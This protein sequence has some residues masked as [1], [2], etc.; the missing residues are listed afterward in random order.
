LVAFATL[1]TA[2]IMISVAPAFTVWS[3]TE[4]LA[5][6]GT[7]MLLVAAVAILHFGRRLSNNLRT[8]ESAATLARSELQVTLDN[9][10]QGLVLCDNSANVVAVNNRFLQLFNIP[11]SKVHRGMEVADLIR[12][13]AQAG[14][15]PSEMAEAL[16]KERLTRQPGSSGRVE[17]PLR[18]RIFD[19]AY[20]PRPEGGWACTFEDVTAQKEAVQ[21]LAFLAQH[22]SLT[23]LANRSLLG[24][25]IDMAIGEGAEFAVMLV[26]LDQFKPVNDALGHATGDALLREVAARLRSLVRDGDTA[27]RLGGDEF[28]ILIRSPCSHEDADRL[29]ATLVQSLTLPFDLEG[30]EIRI[31]G[32]IGVSLGLAAEDDQRGGPPRAASLLRQADLALYRA[33][34]DGRGCH[35]F[36]EPSLDET[37]LYKCA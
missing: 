10:S 21:R 33:K 25:R 17:L 5:P 19:I 31:G 8:A 32:S 12:L 14:G 4:A 2:A 13:Q 35:R 24:E 11:S 1:C 7:A 15:M 3:G 6:A 36:F 18:Q 34:Q 16:I 23:G 28:A 30:R 26:D 29:A 27:A 37:R 20:Q 9:M 22:D